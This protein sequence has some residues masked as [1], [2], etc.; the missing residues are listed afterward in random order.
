MEQFRKA[1]KFLFHSAEEPGLAAQ[2]S[3]IPT[4]EAEQMLTIKVT[5]G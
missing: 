3:P 4:L 1:L 5:R 2:N